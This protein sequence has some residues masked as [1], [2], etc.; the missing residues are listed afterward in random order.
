MDKAW[1]CRAEM[2]GN[3]LA[4]PY[5]RQSTQ[6]QLLDLLLLWLGQL[7]AEAKCMVFLPVC[8]ATFVKFCLQST[9]VGTFWRTFLREESLLPVMS[10]FSEVSGPK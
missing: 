3:C 2:G 7:L 9:L 5:T 8:A 4:A 6:A 10:L 1:R